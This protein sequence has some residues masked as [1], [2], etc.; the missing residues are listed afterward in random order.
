MTLWLTL[1]V[2]SIV[3]G[4]LRFLLS[5]GFSLIFGL[6]RISN[7]MDGSFFMLEPMSA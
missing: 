3:F 4:G 2:N 1:T 6:I 5:A 7:L